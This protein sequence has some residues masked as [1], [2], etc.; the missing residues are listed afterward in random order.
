M[1]PIFL[2]KGPAFVNIPDK[3]V[4]PFN[5]VDIYPLMCEILKIK[6]SP[7]NGT[8]CEVSHLL[9]NRPESC[10]FENILDDVEEKISEGIEQFWSQDFL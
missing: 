10:V 6:P 5:S 9:R 8:L 2:A 1:H 4:K 3:L 7:N